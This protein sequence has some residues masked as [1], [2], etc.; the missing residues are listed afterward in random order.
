MIAKIIIYI[1]IYRVL[2]ATW[3]NN[4][5][6]FPGLSRSENTIGDRKCIGERNSS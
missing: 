3:E 2:T 6:T 5:R 4:S 1:S